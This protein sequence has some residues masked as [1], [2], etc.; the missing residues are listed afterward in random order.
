MMAEAVAEEA[1]NRA[2]EIVRA[3]RV[4]LDEIARRLIE[5]ETIDVVEFQAMFA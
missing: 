4:K 3:Y 1:Y 5:K 2:R